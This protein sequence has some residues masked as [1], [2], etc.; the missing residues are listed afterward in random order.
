VPT[1]GTSVFTPIARTGNGTATTISGA[2]TV[3]DAVI[4]AQRL[5]VNSGDTFAWDRLRGAN[6]YVITNGA[7]VENAAAGATTNSLTGFDVMN[8]FRVGSDSIAA[9]NSNSRTYINWIFS[10]APSFFDEVCYTGNG[11]V[12]TVEHNL[13]AVPELM[14]V[15]SR[16]ANEVWSVY[17]A[18]LGNNSKLLLNTTA[19]FSTGATW[20]FTFPTSSVFTVGDAPVNTS[21]A[22]YV[23][24]LFATCAGVS[25]VGSYTGTGAAQTI[26][27]GFAAGSRFVMIKRTDSTGSWYVWDSARGISSGN[28]PYLLLNNS[29]PEDTGTNYVDT[30]TTGFKV[31]AAAPAELN[32]NGGTYI[33]L[34]IA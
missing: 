14:I 1:V 12:K 21:A 10:R 15:K 32:A 18:A 20:D 31:T 26:N 27:C 11:G 29:D 28:D 13:A 4:D 25:K 8:G 19:A 33:F 24:Y 5:H 17:S 6:N 22:T 23:A 16:S 3:V 7:S 9:I 2:Q 34:A 30:D